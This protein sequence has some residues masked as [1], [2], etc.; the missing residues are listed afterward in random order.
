M[1]CES[2]CCHCGKLLRGAAGAAVAAGEFSGV[3]AP[4]FSAVRTAVANLRGVTLGVEVAV[5][6]KFLRIK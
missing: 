3:S 1:G 2:T 5:I 4:G 6:P